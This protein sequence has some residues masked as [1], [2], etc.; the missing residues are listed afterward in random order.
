[1]PEARGQSGFEPLRAMDRQFLVMEDEN[2]P[3]HVSGFSLYE[4]EPLRGASGGVDLEAFGAAIQGVLHK[5]PRYRQKLAYTPLE[6]H[7]VWVDAADFD[8]GYHLRHLATPPPGSD[9]Q[10]KDVAGWIVSQPLDHTRPLWEMWIVEGIEGGK[11]FAVVTKMHHCMIDGGGGVNLM[12]LLLRTRPDRTMPEARPFEPRPEPSAGELAAYEI[13][14]RIGGPGR[15]LGGLRG[16]AATSPS[17]A[18]A[19]QQRLQA[20]TGLIRN[21]LPASRTPISGVQLGPHRSI[22]WLETPLD[23]LTKLRR[24]L[25]CSLNNL[26]LAVVSGAVR[27]YL[28][29]RDVAL[30][31]LDFRVSIP[32]NVRDESDKK[33]LG[34]RVSSWIVPLPLDEAD[35]LAQLAAITRKTDAL[36][37]S[38][39]ALGVQMLM[40][41][42]EEMPALVGLSARAL[43][44]QISMIVTN[45]P[46]PP[47]PLYLLGCRT[48]SMQPL[49]P[50]VR[51]VALGVALLSYNG[52]LY[53][54]FQADPDRVPDLDRFVQDIR[55]AQQAFQ[56]T[57]ARDRKPES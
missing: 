41:A 55:D 21:A 31:D 50:L 8:L 34:N 47:I 53:W 13:G 32:V 16:F 25:G 18:R 6:K 39:Q 49:V 22:D 7:P 37:E 54:G 51:G 23:E 46:G 56:D 15:V 1:M 4:L 12:Q 17:L 26:V 57:L 5:I 43:Q 9:E 28:A 3:M 11:Y 35:P 30:S 36:K 29:R 40:A 42:A 14:R 20:A 38:N 2:T 48:M 27:R 24:E 52:T 19:L 33:E 10:L 45:V 44:G